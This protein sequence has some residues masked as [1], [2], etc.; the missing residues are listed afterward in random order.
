M[1]A[2]VQDVEELGGAPLAHED[3]A[4]AWRDGTRVDVV[5]D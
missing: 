1:E 2:Y 5:S 3:L 4:T